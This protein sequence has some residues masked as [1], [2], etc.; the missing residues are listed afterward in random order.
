M[1]RWWLVFCFFVQ[2]RFLTFTDFRSCIN[3]QATY[4]FLIQSPNATLAFKHKYPHFIKITI[5]GA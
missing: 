5:C 2:K 1:P 3:F 4:D